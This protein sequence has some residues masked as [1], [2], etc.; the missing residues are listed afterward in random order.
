MITWEEQFLTGTAMRIRRE[1]WAQEDYE[2]KA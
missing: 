1:N 2:N